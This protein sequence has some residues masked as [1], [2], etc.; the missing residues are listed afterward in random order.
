MAL[1][2]P[3]DY[4][5]ADGA[6]VEL[7]FEKSRGF[8]GADAEPLEARLEERDGAFHWQWQGLENAQLQK[9][10][11]LFGEGFTVREVAEQLGIS[12]S[13]AGRLRKNAENLEWLS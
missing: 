10:A 5:P 1:K 3:I 8:F 7:H 13:A 9:A 2:R 6:R 12:K 4:T 11:R